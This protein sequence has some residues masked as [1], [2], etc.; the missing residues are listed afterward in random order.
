MRRRT[1]MH[2]LQERVRLHRLNTHAREVARLLK[3][4]PNTEREYREALT[5]AA[6]LDGPVDAIPSLE[7]LKAA[8]LAQRP[9]VTP[10]QQQSSVAAFQR[11]IEE[12]TDRKGAV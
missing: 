7:A 1:E 5:R 4:G 9:P 2:G 8:V 12:L 3:M 11:C 10:P 6:L